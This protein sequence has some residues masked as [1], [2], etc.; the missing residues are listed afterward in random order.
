MVTEIMSA[1]AER[2]CRYMNGRR[3]IKI[4]LSDH[5]LAFRK[6]RVAKIR[7]QCQMSR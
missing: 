1:F 2:I 7:L 6:L 5:P 3:R 4:M